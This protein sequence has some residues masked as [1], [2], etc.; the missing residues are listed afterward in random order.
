MPIFV[1]RKTK[2]QLVCSYFEERRKLLTRYL[3]SVFFVKMFKMFLHFFD[4][5]RLD[6]VLQWR[7]SLVLLAAT[8]NAS[9]T[10]ACLCSA[11]AM[12]YCDAPFVRMRNDVGVMQTTDSTWSGGVTVR[13][14]DACWSIFELWSDLFDV[15]DHLHGVTV[16]WNTLKDTHT[17]SVFTACSSLSALVGR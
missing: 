12:P 11:N 1:Y 14:D 6:E 16:D 3:P 5:N 2:W 13:T 7:H 17:H 4:S 15:F 9:D 8:Y 10:T